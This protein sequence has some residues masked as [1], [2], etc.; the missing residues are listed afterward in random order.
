MPAGLGNWLPCPERGCD[1]ASQRYCERCEAWVGS[2]R[3]GST[4]EECEHEEPE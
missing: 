2:C 4:G 3:C 1:G